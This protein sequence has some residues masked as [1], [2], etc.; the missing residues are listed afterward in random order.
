MNKNENCGKIV[1]RAEKTGSNND[2]IHM[3]F[4][5]INGKD[6]RWFFTTKPFLR[7]FKLSDNSAIK[8]HETEHKLL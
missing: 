2:I 8:V 7:L 1:V 5:L 4:A 3:K 6:N